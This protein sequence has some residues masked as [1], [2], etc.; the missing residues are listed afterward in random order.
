MTG[1]V[2]VAI[3]AVVLLGLSLLLLPGLV[4]GSPSGLVLIA[5]I[6]GPAMALAVDATVRDEP[7]GERRFEELEFG[8]GVSLPLLWLLLL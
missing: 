4:G 6:L 7:I 1:Y 5:L 3:P 2:L 8:V